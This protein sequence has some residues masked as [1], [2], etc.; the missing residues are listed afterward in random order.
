MPNPLITQKKLIITFIFENGKEVKVM[1]EDLPDELSLYGDNK[2]VTIE[3]IETMIEI[4][5]KQIQKMNKLNQY[6]EDWKSIGGMEGYLKS[7]VKVEIFDCLI[8]DNL[9]SFWEIHTPLKFTYLLRVKNQE[10][11]INVKDLSDQEDQLSEEYITI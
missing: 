1:C 6:D 9:F 5:K 4:G 8:C 3:Y 11:K 10:D 7:K 2:D